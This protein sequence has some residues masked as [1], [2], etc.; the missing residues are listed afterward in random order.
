MLDAYKCGHVGKEIDAKKAGKVFV[1]YAEA[2]SEKVE[3]HP[4]TT[5]VDCP[6]CKGR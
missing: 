4:A 6:S 1:T 3:R 5:T 2:R